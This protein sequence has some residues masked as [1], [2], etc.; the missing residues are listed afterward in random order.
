M[1][2]NSHAKSNLIAMLDGCPM[3]SIIDDACEV[4][5]LK[6]VMLLTKRRK[7][8]DKLIG[9]H[10]ATMTLISRRSEVHEIIALLSEAP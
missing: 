2:L 5:T 6:I 10:G 8:L 9:D 7:E 1:K 3:D 4:L